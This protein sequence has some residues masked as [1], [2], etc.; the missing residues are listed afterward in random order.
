M[1]GGGGGAAKLVSV[2]IRLRFLGVA[3]GWVLVRYWTLSWV[4]SMNAS[5]S[6][7]CWRDSS[8][9]VM[10]LAAARSPMPSVDDAGDGQLAGG[11]DW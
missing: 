9:M 1:A 5:S 7:A 6:D 11:G 2:M 8:W 4:S 10:P 3:V